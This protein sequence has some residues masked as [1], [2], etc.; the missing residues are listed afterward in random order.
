MERLKGHNV[1]PDWKIFEIV[2]GTK[3]GW[4]KVLRCRVCHKFVST[5]KV[6]SNHEETV[7]CYHCKSENILFT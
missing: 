1:H 2:Y 3:E 5:N 4:T 7:S 6:I